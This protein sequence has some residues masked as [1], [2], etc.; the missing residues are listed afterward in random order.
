MHTL[1]MCHD[2]RVRSGQVRVV[3]SQKRVGT[4]VVV[5]RARRVVRPVH[6]LV[7]CSARA[8]AVVASKH[9]PHRSSIAQMK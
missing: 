9:Q 6:M 8:K 2:L 5:F 1:G 4:R 3:V 7:V